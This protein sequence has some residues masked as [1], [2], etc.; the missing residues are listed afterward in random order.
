[1]GEAFLASEY[2][3]PPEER[4]RL[5]MG[6][7]SGIFSGRD[8]VQTSRL[9]NITDNILGGCMCAILKLYA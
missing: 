7:Y 4:T 5:V 9:R 3:L 2:A 1:M 6:E 8:A